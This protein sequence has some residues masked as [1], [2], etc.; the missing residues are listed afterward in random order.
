MLN[1]QPQ[2]TVKRLD[3][4]VFQLETLGQQVEHFPR[5][6]LHGSRYTLGRLFRLSVSFG[7]DV[8]LF[9]VANQDARVVISSGVRY[10]NVGVYDGVFGGVIDSSSSNGLCEVNGSLHLRGCVVFILC[11]T[12]YKYQGTLYPPGF[13]QFPL[14]FSDGGACLE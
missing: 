7:F 3:F 10:L 12:D 6:F 2:S 14:Q 9:R 5:L 11:G 13:V 8:V 4:H 1:P